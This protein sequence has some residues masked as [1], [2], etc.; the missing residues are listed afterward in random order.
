M[1]NLFYENPMLDVLHQVV[2]VGRLMGAL[3]VMAA[4]PVV[5]M[6]VYLIVCAYLA[7]KKAADK[8]TNRYNLWLLV[9]LAASGLLAGCVGDNIADIAQAQAAAEAAK[10]AQESAKAAQIA[11]GGL[12]AAVVAPWVVAILVVATGVAWVWATQILPAMRGQM[13][14]SK[15][16]KTVVIRQGERVESVDAQQRPQL[17]PPQPMTMMDYMLYRDMRREEREETNRRGGY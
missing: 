9:A 15:A 12:S 8:R 10:A 4:L 1:S 2:W 11:A 14:A 5:G 6:N 16:A 3:V 17:P 13:P 7:S